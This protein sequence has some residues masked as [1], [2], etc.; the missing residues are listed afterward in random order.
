MKVNPHRRPAQLLYAIFFQTMF[1][2]F[3]V[4]NNDCL[5][6]KYSPESICMWLVFLRKKTFTYQSL[7][8]ILTL[9]SSHPNY[10]QL[11]INKVIPSHFSQFTGKRREI[12]ENYPFAPFVLMIHQNGS[13]VLAFPITR[14]LKKY[15]KINKNKN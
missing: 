11:F 6:F 9:P 8:F 15:L 3:K 13:D 14:I 7:F 12:T 4:L 1:A 10:C 5:T 2:D